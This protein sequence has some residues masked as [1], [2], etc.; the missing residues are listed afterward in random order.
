MVA[1]ADIITGPQLRAVV[2]RAVKTAAQAMVAV[3]AAAGAVGISDVD[4]PAAAQVGLLA[5][6]L[7]LLTSIASWGVGEP[8]PSLGQE[9]V[10]DF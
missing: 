8:G 7:S 3:V 4:W 1:V 9:S 5:G 6:V 10:D 2:E